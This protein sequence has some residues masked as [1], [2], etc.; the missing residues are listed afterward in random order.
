MDVDEFLDREIKEL[1]E[2]TG[3]KAKTEIKSL[4]LEH[5]DITDEIQKYFNKDD[6]SNKIK[7]ALEKK[8]FNS[9]ERLFYEFWEKLGENV[10]WDPKIH[11]N[12]T[13]IGN[14]IKNALN[15][16]DSEVSKKKSLSSNL[17]SM[18]KENILHGNYKAALSQYS[19]LM[20]LHNEMPSFLFEEKR[21]MH[22][23]ILKLYM[24]L[25]E[26]IDF[27]FL[28]KF[29]ASLN[30]IRQLVESV[31]LGLKNMDL[32]NSKKTYLEMLKIYTNLPAG[33]L[34]EK[35]SIANEILELYKEIS[36]SLEIKNLEG[37]LTFE[38]IAEKTSP[39]MPTIPE[40]KAPAHKKE[41]EKL[42][43]MSL[44]KKIRLK[45][46][47]IREKSGIVARAA[48]G[49]EL[50]KMLIKRRLERAKLKIDKGLHDEAK[51]EFESVLRLDSNNAE[52]KKMLSNVQK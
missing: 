19:E 46:P 39:F 52:A 2:D 14:E 40:I 9:A 45:R 1:A 23:E 51:K 3:N 17:I 29:N 47:R 33:F 21:T 20:E 38:K 41:I 15:N 12:L 5:P 13:K 31:K 49:K 42:R 11:D 32:D 16:L 44:Q 4:E 18:A 37:Q 25:K 28:N 27:V 10:E 6:Y 34:Y 24:E 50:K 43:E 35:I 22:N 48:K 26:K 7:L 30:Q 8:D 36:I